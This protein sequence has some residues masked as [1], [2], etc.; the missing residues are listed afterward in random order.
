MTDRLLP[1]AAS[2]IGLAGKLADCAEVARLSDADHN[3]AAALALALSNLET[4]CRRFLVSELP[5]LTEES[6]GCA[7]LNDA[8]GDIFETL[9]TVLYQVWLARYFRLLLED[10]KPRWIAE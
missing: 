4:A 6:A 3:E 7:E 1:D 9:R 2:E 5:R 8:L 10:A